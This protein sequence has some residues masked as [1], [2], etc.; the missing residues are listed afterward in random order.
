M[1]IKTVHKG[2]EKRFKVNARTPVEACEAAMNLLGYMP[3][4]VVIEY[5]PKKEEE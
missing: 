2:V 4:E 5:K 3:E 1:N